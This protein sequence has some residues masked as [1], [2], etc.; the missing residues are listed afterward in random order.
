VVGGGLALALDEDRQVGSVLAVP[1]LEW[2]EQLKTV[3]RGGHGD[4]YV[5]AVLGRVLVGVLAW[6]VAVGRETLTGGLLQLELLAVRVLEGVCSRIS[7][8]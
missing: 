7:I 5:G 6:V 3:G 8:C 2:L 4:V 1:G